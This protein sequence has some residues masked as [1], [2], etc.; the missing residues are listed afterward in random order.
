[1]KPRRNRKT[2]IKDGWIDYKGEQ[3]EICNSTDYGI[4]KEILLSFINQ[5]DTSINLHKRVL[6]IRLDFHINYHTAT[7]DKFSNF[8]KQIKQWI[9]RN[10]GIDKIGHQ[11]VRE[12][13]K[14]KKQHYHLVLLLDGNKIQNPKKL[15]ETIRE[16]WGPRGSIYIP[17]N[18]YIYIDKHNVSKAR[19][20]AIYRASYMAKI[21][22]KS[23]RDLQTKDYS[24]SRLKH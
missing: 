4:Y 21:R 10:Y 2:V 20:E 9:T 7:N 23:Y 16:K 11:W 15:N 6:F 13:E 19:P 3:I 5:L 17:E 12:Q 14:S 22:G 1:M 24:S 8:L 18:C